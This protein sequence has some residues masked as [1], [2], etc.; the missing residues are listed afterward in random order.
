MMGDRLQ[1]TEVSVL[2]LMAGGNQVAVEFVIACDIKGTR[3]RY[4]TKS[5]T[6]GRSTRMARS[7]GCDT[8][9]TRPSTSRR[10]KVE[11]Q[12]RIDSPKD[13]PSLPAAVLNQ[14]IRPADITV[15]IELTTQGVPSWTART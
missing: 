11:H 1:V 15:K 2:S 10:R 14:N 6:C 12:L 13:L 8:T 7:P 4:A 5:S 3:R 9:Q